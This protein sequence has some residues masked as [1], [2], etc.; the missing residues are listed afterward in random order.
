[1]WVE[2]VGLVD[3]RWHLCTRDDELRPAGNDRCTDSGWRYHNANAL[4]CL[5][6]V[7]CID[8][9]PTPGC[10]TVVGVGES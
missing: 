10:A 6:E 2:D 7:L 8:W 3:E 5:F 1:M 9:L 4:A